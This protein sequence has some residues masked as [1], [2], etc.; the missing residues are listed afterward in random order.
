MT[1]AQN[2]QTQPTPSDQTDSKVN[3]QIST[4]NTLMGSLLSLF[5]AIIVTQY[6]TDIVWVFILI[7]VM[8]AMAIT[9]ILRL[10]RPFD[11]YNFFLTLI[12]TALFTFALYQRSQDSTHPISTQIFWPL[13]PALI[14]V[15]WVLLLEVVLRR[16]CLAR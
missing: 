11:V 13:A 9:I 16:K 8:A 2:P 15:V 3:I 7:G 10:G 6:F 4:L 1:A 5:N 14:Y 12:V